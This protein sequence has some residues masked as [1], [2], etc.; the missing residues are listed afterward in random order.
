MASLYCYSIH[1]DRVQKTKEKKIADGSH[2]AA[3]L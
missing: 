2:N 1:L 3:K